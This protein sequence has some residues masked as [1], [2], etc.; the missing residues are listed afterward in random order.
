VI[1][2]PD[3]PPIKARIGA[4]IS[5]DT[6]LVVLGTGNRLADRIPGPE[7]SGFAALAR[8]KSTTQPVLML[9]NGDVVYDGECWWGSEAA[10][11]TMIEDAKRSG[12]RVRFISIDQVRA[13]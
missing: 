8:S 1:F 3:I 10:L 9:D 11:T 7:A 2:G 6:D 13:G 4:I 12:R 5:S